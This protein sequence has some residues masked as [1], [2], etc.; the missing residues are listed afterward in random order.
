MG[1]SLYG[2]KQPKIG[3]LLSMNYFLF[4]ILG[5]FCISLLLAGHVSAVASPFFAPSISRSQTA[6]FT[7]QALS[8]RSRQI[9]RTFTSAV[10]AF[11]F[12][13]TALAITSSVQTAPRLPSQLESELYGM[14]SILEDY[15]YRHSDEVVGNFLVTGFVLYIFIR[16]LLKSHQEHFNWDPTPPPSDKPK[17]T[18]TW[19]VALI[20]LGT[21]L[22]FFMLL[23]AAL[24]ADSGTGVA[25]GMV[26]QRGWTSSLW[27]EM[28][29]QIISPSR[30]SLAFITRAA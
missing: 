9:P 5:V 24:S 1:Y 16:V 25:L 26:A 13:L 30:R 21:L 3:H 27:R 15:M 2:L 4:R 11:Q 14:R 28:T 22:I 29:R 6:V 18:L 17:N 12:L 8:N 23:P 10:T 19:Q 20:W 7:R